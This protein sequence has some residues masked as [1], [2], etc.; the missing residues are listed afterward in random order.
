[1]V[2]VEAVPA[3]ATHG[4]R[5]TVLRDGRTDAEVAF[6]E[7]DRPGAFHLGAFS[8]GGLVAVASFSPE[9]TSLRPGRRA[10]RLRAMAVDPAY[11]GRGIGRTVLEEAVPRLQA[12]GVEVLWAN[13]R[14]AAL[15]FYRRFGMEVVGDGFI[16]DVLERPMPHHVVVMDLRRPG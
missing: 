4:L 6:P 13:A 11:Q 14:D 10:V 16:L 3:A 9:P 15:N 7:D 5:R 1:V 2:Q 8:D 12:E